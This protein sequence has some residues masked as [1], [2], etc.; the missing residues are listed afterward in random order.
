[1]ILLLTLYKILINY[2]ICSKINGVSAVKDSV[3]VY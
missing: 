3:R 1:M 2:V